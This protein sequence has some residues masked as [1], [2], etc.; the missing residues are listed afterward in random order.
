MSRIAVIVKGYPRLSETFIAQE[1]RGLEVR[2]Q[3]LLIV[4]LRHPTEKHV[5]DVHRE[6][7]ADCLYLPEYLKDD[8]KRVRAGRRHAEALETFPHLKAVFERDLARDRS[9]NR[10]RRLGQACVLAHEL[11]E[12]VTGIYVHYLHT[13]SSV[14]R[15]ASL[16]TGLPF[17]FSAHA[18]D[19][20]TSPVWELSEKIADARWGVTCTQANVEHLKALAADPTKIERVY[21]G[22][23]LSNFPPPLD[24]RGRTGPLRILSVGRLVE[25]KGYGDVLSALAR[26]PASLDWQ[27]A[28]IGGGNK[29]MLAARA[30]R[31]GLADRIEWL[32][33][34]PRE[35][36]IEEG[37][38]A[39]LF[40]LP[41][42]IAKS[43]DRDGLPN[44]LMEALAL[45]LP[46]ISTRV[47]AI[48]EIIT[49][50]E[51]GLLI[52][53]RDPTALT[54]AIIRLADD[55]ELRHRLGQAGS[56]RVRSDFSPSPGLDR[57]VEKLALFR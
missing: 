55:P 29:D 50:N 54:D 11:P 23:D 57:I 33:S 51:T 13:P 37:L 38:K 15:Y 27:F 16:L 53:Q 9:V 21:H 34:Q 48:P 25:K 40:V 56:R 8:P 24:R 1:I 44:V 43:G 5:H 31:L 14:G 6:I 36:V 26:L 47:S 52:E 46:A 35:I 45:G 42:R 12:D 32:G 28:H 22:L 30:K 18:K 17:A 4:S 10:W 20:Y 41:S 7:E 39:D 49:D 19:I 3:K 2:G